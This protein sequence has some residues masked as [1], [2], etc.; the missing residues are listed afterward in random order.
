MIFNKHI[1]RY[2]LKYAA[3]LLLGILVLFAED[4]LLLMVPQMY[5]R[6]INGIN[7]GMVSVNGVRV[8]FDM[9]YLVKEICLPLVFAVILTVV[10]QF[11]WRALI[12]S[13]TIRVDMDLRNRMFDNARR[14]DAHFYSRNKVGSLMSLFT[15]DLDTVQECFGWG[16]SMMADALIMGVL[17][18]G[19]MVN[20]DPTL[21]VYSMIPMVALLISATI[22]GKYMAKKWRIRQEAFSRL[23]DFTQERVSGMSVVKAF[24]KETSELGSFK[25]LNIENEKANVKHTKASVLMRILVTLF[26]QSVT[27]I[28]MGYGGVLVK[29]G[30]FNSGQVVEFIGYFTNAVFPVMAASELID[31]TSRG[32][33]SMQRIAELL[34]A[35]PEVVDSP[36]A[37]DFPEMQG[38]IAIKNLTFSY[39]GSEKPVLKNISLSIRAGERVGIVGRTG[40]GKTTLAD[41]LLRT[42]NVPEGTIFMDGLDIGKLKLRD[43]RHHFAYVPQDN[44]LFSDTIENNIAFGVRGAE[45]AAVQQAAVYADVDENIRGFSSGYQTTL[46]ERGV[47]ISGGQKQRVSIARAFMMDAPVLILDDAVS[48]VDTKTERTILDNMQKIRQGKTTL[49]IAHRISTVEGMDRIFFLEDG[50][51]IAEG[52]HQQLLETCPAYANLVKLQKLEQ[53][54]AE[55][56]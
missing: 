27:A 29:E 43:L 51:L 14:L 24:V 50:C 22:L 1:N 34:D 2:Y 9:Q 31:M 28:I 8:P 15:N 33:A 12:M 25:K 44:F 55:N 35:E 19:K 47:T 54:G 18:I 39:P 21:T 56:E 11:S 4:Y 53:E 32:K 6:V 30:A 46:G 52:T 7:T 5:P 40:S 3:Y 23:S 16:F 48:A 20:M 26:V 49:M 36:D 41:L 13:S 10:A 38:N 45:Q 37:V 17:A 42:Y